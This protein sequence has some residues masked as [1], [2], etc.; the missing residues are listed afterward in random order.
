MKTQVKNHAMSFEALQALRV[1]DESR[2]S[3]PAAREGNSGGW[4]WHRGGSRIAWHDPSSAV[5]YKIETAYY[6]SNETE[7]RNAQLLSEMGK[8]WA[9]ETSLR[10]PAVCEPQAVWPAVS[11]M[12]LLCE[13][14]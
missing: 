7:H 1:H 8:S 14:C 2:A 13:N 3:L 6:G 11:L 12:P 4:K 9:P 5:V 10:P